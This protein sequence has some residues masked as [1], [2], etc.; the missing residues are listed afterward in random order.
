MLETLE[1]S[2]N[3]FKLKIYYLYLGW[4]R[5]N[6]LKNHNTNNEENSMKNM[7]FPRILLTMK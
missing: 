2:P 4:L 1:T 3:L 7:S 5:L 6:V